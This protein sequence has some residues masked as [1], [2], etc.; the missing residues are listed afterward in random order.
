MKTLFIALVASVLF[1]SQNL[2]A[3]PRLQL[4]NMV[5]MNTTTHTYTFKDTEMGKVRSPDIAISALVVP[6]D[7]IW[8]T[9]AI[10]TVIAIIENVDPADADDT[11]FSVQVTKYED[12]NYWHV[13]YF[14]FSPKKVKSYTATLTIWVN[15]TPLSPVITL[16]GTGANGVL[17]FGTVKINED[18]TQS[19]LFTDLNAEPTLLLRDFEG[20]GHAPYFGIHSQEW[21]GL[22]STE[23][24]TVKFSPAEPL[25]YKAVLAANDGTEH[26]LTMLGKGHDIPLPSNSTKDVWYYLQFADGTNRVIQQN[27]NGNRLTVCEIWE[28]DDAQLWKVVSK[29]DHPTFY[30]KADTTLRIHYFSVSP[31]NPD[32]PNGYYATSAV[33]DENA[34]DLTNIYTV[35]QQTTTNYSTLSR[36][37]GNNIT[38]YYMKPESD[39]DNAPLGRNGSATD[40][41]SKSYMRFVFHSED[42]KTSIQTV[43]TVADIQ[44]YPNPATD[45]VK[46]KLPADALSVSILNALGQRLQTLPVKGEKEPMISVSA[47]N[48]GLY[49]IKIEK[50]AGTELGKFIKR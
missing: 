35:D 43:K 41:Y 5:G 24:V 25:I 16:K 46:V 13:G 37:A 4:G 3:Q 14:K 26:S 33:P 21:D 49:F 27:G 17:D 29:I 47:L 50:K 30:S 39:A 9:F 32:K 20:N 2:Y 11:I 6:T 15:D 34:T 45:F 22:G 12:D 19:F 28:G 10:D 42:I 23:S 8:P 44:I 31:A 1:F 38:A 7:G 36:Q 48:P 40:D 18:I